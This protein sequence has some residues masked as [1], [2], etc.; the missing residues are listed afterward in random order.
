[1]RESAALAHGL[2]W[3]RRGDDGLW[4]DDVSMRKNE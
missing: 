2:R 4:E 1:M 3:R